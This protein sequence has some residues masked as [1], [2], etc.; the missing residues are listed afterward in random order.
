MP[1]DTLHFGRFPVHVSHGISGRNTTNRHFSGSPVLRVVV[2]NDPSD[3]RS[4]SPHSTE[5][6]TVD[7]HVERLA[8]EVTSDE[9]D[10]VSSIDIVLPQA[11]NLARTR[12][13][14]A[15]AF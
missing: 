9:D 4:G 8:F 10:A 12:S 15:R 6:D 14:A 5:L 2:E 11:Q 3:E 7:M 13:G 1:V